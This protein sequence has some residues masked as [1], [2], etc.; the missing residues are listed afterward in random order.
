[1]KQTFVALLIASLCA[2]CGP[3]GS[4][5]EGAGGST[6][7]SSSVVSTSAS[8]AAST[9]AT[10]SSST[11]G[12]GPSKL[13]QLLAAFVSDDVKRDKLAGDFDDWKPEQMTLSKSFAWKVVN[14]A[15]GARY[16]L[17][18]GKQDWRADR[19]SRAYGYDPYGEMSMVPSKTGGH[20]ERFFAVKDAKMAPRTVRVWLPLQK[21]TH[22]LYVHDGQNLF[23]PAAPWGS[24][25]LQ[26]SAPKAMMLVGIDNTPARMSEYTHVQDDLG[27]GK[28]GGAGDAYAD[29]VDAT[30]RSLIQKHYGEPALIGT[31]GSSLGGLISLHIA[32]RHGS[33]YRF[34][35]SLSGTLGWGSIGAS[36]HFE[37][38]IERYA[39]KGHGKTALYIDSG[40]GGTTCADSDKDGIA[41]DDATASDNY[42]TNKQMEGVL[43]GLGYKQDVDLWHWHEPNAKHNEAAWAARVWRPLQ[44]FEGLK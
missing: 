34:A 4:S 35:A 26:A 7:A 28:I 17:T 9:T 16:K 22:L 43:A 6:S 29:Y 3:G 19:W 15:E 2:A 8:N 18:D 39:K 40:G 31:M 5:V 33:K 23:D 41:D 38:M 44:I 36:S 27:S 42:C 37:T 12:M 25:K 10:S 1:M 32:D 24:W 11:T 13:D 30:V 14:A 20:L 21:A